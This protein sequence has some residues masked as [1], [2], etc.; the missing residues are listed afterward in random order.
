MQI[1][2]QNGYLGLVIFLGWI[3][4][5]GWGVFT[6]KTEDPMTGDLNWIMTCCFAGALAWGLTEYTFAQQFMYLQ[7]SLIGLQWGLW[8]K[9]ILS[10]SNN[11]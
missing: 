10:Q 6:F 2:A 1:T 7:F 4:A 8:K 9:G 11:A 5:Y 3:L